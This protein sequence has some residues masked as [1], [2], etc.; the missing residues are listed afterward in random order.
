MSCMLWCKLDKYNQTVPRAFKSSG[1]CLRNKMC[2]KTW[3]VTFYTAYIQKTLG[4]HLTQLID[5]WRK[6]TNV[7]FKNKASVVK[8]NLPLFYG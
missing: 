6:E 1:H 5:L 2:C 7:W 4:A 8:Y 3:L